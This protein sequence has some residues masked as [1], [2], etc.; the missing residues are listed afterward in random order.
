MVAAALSNVTET[1][2]K[3][4]VDAMRQAGLLGSV[5]LWLGEGA[6]TYSS[7]PG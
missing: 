5:P 2:V 1:D 3:G 7:K 4:Y 6:T